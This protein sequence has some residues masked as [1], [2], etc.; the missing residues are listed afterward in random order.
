MT[1]DT[2]FTLEELR[3]FL[4]TCDKDIKMTMTN[5][6]NSVMFSPSDDGYINWSDGIVKIFLEELIE[7]REK[8]ENKL[9]NNQD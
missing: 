1:K 5:T 7:L 6:W 3:G 9:N 8:K 2:R 4:K